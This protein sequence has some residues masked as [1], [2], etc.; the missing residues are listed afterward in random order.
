[1][2]GKGKPTRHFLLSLSAA[3]TCRSWG[4]P[5]CDCWAAQNTN[6]P[7][8]LVK[9]TTDSPA[10]QAKESISPCRRRGWAAWQNRFRKHKTPQEPP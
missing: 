7:G 9:E 1:M 8:L 10:E 6:T 4:R 3:S 5:Q 2:E